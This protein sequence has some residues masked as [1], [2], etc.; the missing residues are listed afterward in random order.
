MIEKINLNGLPEREDALDHYF[1][2]LLFD[3]LQDF[4][5]RD[6][7]LSAELTETGLKDLSDCD[8]HR[9]VNGYNSSN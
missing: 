9:T 4:E 5:A 1:Q 2:T 7:K 6:H 8:T 3:G